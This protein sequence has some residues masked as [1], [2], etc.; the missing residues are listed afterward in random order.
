MDA[1]GTT[2]V[3]VETVGVKRAKDV[4]IIYKER[5]ASIGWIDGGDGHHFDGNR[6]GA[7]HFTELVADGARFITVQTSFLEIRRPR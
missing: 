4:T 2:A 7:N 1:Y 5:A 6:H 3:F